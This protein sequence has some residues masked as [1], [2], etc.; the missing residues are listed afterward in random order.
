MATGSLDSTNDAGRPDEGALESG[1]VDS[2]MLGLLEAAPDAIVIVDNN[3]DIALVNE[4]AEKVF[5]YSRSEMV[6]REVELLVPPRYHQHHTRYRTHYF[7]TPERRPMDNGHVLY[8]RRRDGSEFPAEISLSPLEVEGQCWV[9]C[10]IR[11]ITARRDYELELE[12]Q[13]R[14][15]RVANELLTELATLDGLTGLKNH[16]AFHERLSEEFERALRYKSPLS[17]VM[18]DVDH[19]KE[20]ND[21]FGHLAGD[22]V[23]VKFGLILLAGARQMDTVARYGGE[24]FVILLPNIDSAGAIASAERFRRAIETA[25]WPLRPITASFGIATF[26]VASE[27]EISVGGYCFANCKALVDAADQALYEAKRGGRNRVISTYDAAAA[28]P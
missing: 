27:S 2:A 15:L 14:K 25:V 11:D 1:A 21:A 23:L 4:Q 26:R 3:G 6:G 5:G 20:F 24:E 19:F 9:I 12:E 10:I 17:I 28:Q 8:G 13:G 7:H 16:R 18:A 22:E